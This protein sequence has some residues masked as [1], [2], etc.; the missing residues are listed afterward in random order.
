MKFDFKSSYEYVAFSVIA[1]I[2]LFASLIVI[3]SFF[4]NR[5]VNTLI[6]N[7]IV[8]TNNHLA[9]KDLYKR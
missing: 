1:L 3:L 4:Q 2:F 7:C 9:C 5:Q 8:E 6:D